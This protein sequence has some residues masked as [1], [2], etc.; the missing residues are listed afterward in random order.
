MADTFA[1]QS[2][3]QFGS[4]AWSLYKNMSWP[5]LEAMSRTDPWL[6][7][8]RNTAEANGFD[9]RN[10]LSQAATSGGT[11]ATSIYSNFGKTAATQPSAPA[12]GMPPVATPQQVQ[13]TVTRL[14]QTP[15]PAVPVTGERL[16]GT[17]MTTP[18]QRAQTGVQFTN[19]GRNVS[20]PTGE[21][22]STESGLNRF[23]P[24]LAKKS[25]EELQ[26]ARLPV[27][28]LVA[29]QQAAQA[30]YG[31]ASS[32]A[33]R[34]GN[35]TSPLVRQEELSRLQNPNWIRQE[36]MRRF[37]QGLLKPV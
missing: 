29:G 1:N 22:I 5:K 14:Q 26:I 12:G 33:R 35:L 32:A 30:P 36:A 34:A 15:P 37:Q 18:G 28:S 6:S 11:M 17:P 13:A 27:G 4:Q 2:R 24:E 8:F 3:S 10:A 19:Q 20:A 16:T 7:A 9:W 23:N 21:S 25:L 31:E